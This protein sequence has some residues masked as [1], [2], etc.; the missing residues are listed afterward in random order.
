MSY[1]N[2]NNGE[3]L[4][5]VTPLRYIKNILRLIPCKTIIQSQKRLQHECC[6]LT[7]LKQLVINLI[8]LLLY[9]E[10]LDSMDRNIRTH[11]FPK[12]HHLYKKLFDHL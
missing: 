11:L 2:N 8:E 6:S 3:N 12:Q 1:D 10:E 5:P 9:T 7:N 4:V